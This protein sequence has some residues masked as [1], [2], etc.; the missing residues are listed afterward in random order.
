M[1]ELVAGVLAAGQRFVADS[2]AQMPSTGV[3]HTLLNRAAGLFTFMLVAT[4]KHVANLFAFVVF[5]IFFL[6]LGHEFVFQMLWVVQLVAFDLSHLFA[7]DTCLGHQGLADF[8]VIVVALLSAL[9]LGARQKL[10]TS[11]VTCGDRI[12]A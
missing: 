3:S 12:F 5:N 10:L 9:V 6:F 7:A 11:L 2:Q 4:F 8:T 1:A